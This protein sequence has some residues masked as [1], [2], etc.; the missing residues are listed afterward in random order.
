[1]ITRRGAAKLSK[2]PDFC[3]LPIYT[4][5][6]KPVSGTNSAKKSDM[7]AIPHRIPQQIKHHLTIDN[8]IPATKISVNQIQK[9]KIVMFNP[10]S[11]SEKKSR[12]LS[13]I[14]SPRDKIELIR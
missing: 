4:S 2:S 12:H 9:S 14:S 8:K 3:Q 11:S 13:S 6:P 10:E 7:R 5:K 1:M